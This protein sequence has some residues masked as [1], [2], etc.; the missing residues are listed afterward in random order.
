MCRK[1]QLFGIFA[2]G[3]GLGLLLAICFESM[4]F[5]GCLGA[6]LLAVGCFLFLRR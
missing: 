5:C 2:V 3:F 1:N 4:F 6:I